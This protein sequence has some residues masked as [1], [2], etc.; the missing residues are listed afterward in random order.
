M[1]RGLLLTDLNA[2]EWLCVADSSRLIGR[3]IAGA[4]SLPDSASGSAEARTS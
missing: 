2:F 3:S 4:G 1:V